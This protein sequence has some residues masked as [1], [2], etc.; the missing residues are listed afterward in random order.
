MP[1]IMQALY[2]SVSGL[3]SFSQT[4]NT[5]SNNVSNMNTPGF[6][7]S[8]SFLENVLDDDGSKVA[9]S[10]LNLSEGQ[11]E[12]TSTATDVAIDGKGFFILQDPQGVT[13]Y[14]RSGQ[15]QFND[16]GQ[17]V[18]S[19]NQYVVQGYATN[20][21]YGP[22]DISSLQ[23]LP[24]QATTSIS[25]AGNIVPSTP[26]TVNNVTV[27]D[28]QGNSHVLSVSLTN[29]TT[30]TGSWAV[31]IAD[32]SGKSLGSGEIR[33]STDGTLQAGYTTVTATG[34]WGPGPQ[35]LTFN[36]GTAGGLSGTTTFSGGTATLAAQVKDG[37]G[38]VGLSSESFDSTGTLQLSY[39]D[40]ET[41]QGPQLALATFQDESS[42][43]MI[44]GNLYLQPQTQT[45]QIGKPSSTVFG[46]ID[47]SS[48]EMSNV[49]LT[50][51]LADMIVIQRGYQ[52]SS[53]V[54]TVSSDML[55]QLYDSTRGG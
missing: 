4:L 24:A 50:Q 7:G 33:F 6:R 37:H 34:N 53:R 25:M 10:G 38:V 2:N 13:Y 21:S 47:G 46:K 32:S 43:T 42:L 44:Q 23:K 5:I 45:A 26:D 52:A 18:D 40:G 49:D 41:K 12:Q 20:G 11:I 51:E 30:T 1:S 17:L 29:S 54:M 19:V 3:F 22:I 14:T 31:N 8:D 27:Y 39:A 55:Q 35:A 9:G 15:F 36:F 16:K 48:L 28:A